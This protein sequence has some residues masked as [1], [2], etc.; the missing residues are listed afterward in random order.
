MDGTARNGEHMV[1]RKS[2]QTHSHLS[3]LGDEWICGTCTGQEDQRQIRECFAD[4]AA[5]RL[6]SGVSVGGAR[7][8]LAMQ[9]I[10]YYLLKMLM[11]IQSLKTGCCLTQF[12]IA[13]VTSIHQKSKA[14]VTSV[15]LIFAVA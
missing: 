5:L 14:Y 10:A 12:S 2:I 13:S 3:S 4:F 6:P 8:V 15:S 9:C 11:L 7:A 1:I